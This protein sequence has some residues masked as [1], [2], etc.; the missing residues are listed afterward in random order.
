M[1]AA[2]GSSQ[3]L[4]LYD[5]HNGLD[6]L[7]DTGAAVSLFPHQSVQ[8]CGPRR[9][10]QADGSALPSWGR[11]NFK[12]S[13]AGR[14][15]NFSF[16]LAAV[17]RPILGIDFLKSNKWIV[18]IPGRQILDAVTMAPVFTVPPATEE[19]DKPITAVDAPDKIQQLLAEFP[20]IIGA[21]F[22][23]LKPQHGV[24]HHIITAGPPVHAKYRR[25]D[26]EKLAAARAEFS[27][28]EKA[29]IIRPSSSPWSSPLHMVPKSDGTW[30]PCGDYRLLNAKTVP[31]R[32]PVPN[33]HDLSARL[34]GCTVFTKLDL[35]KG[36]Y[37][38]P[39]N[40]DDIPKTCVVTPFGGFQMVVHAFW[41]P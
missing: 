27:R 17:D 28:M 10:R 14:E 41:T 36:Y 26:P 38:V 15:F 1:F 19:D 4:Y 34:H 7:V 22:S 5:D 33:V 11:R 9:L 16:L 20:E 39:M 24:T 32:Y 8:P 21:S 23:D 2:G 18:D 13:F 37:Q 25:L 12:L 40:P 30:R 35:V 3:L 6:F 31:D 29:G